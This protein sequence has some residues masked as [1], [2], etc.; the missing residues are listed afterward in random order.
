MYDAAA[1]A[2][3]APSIPRKRMSALIGLCRLAVTNTGVGA[4]VEGAED[5]PG[6]GS[7]RIRRF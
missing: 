3:A 5:T 6:G 4:G 2:H 1:I 7:T